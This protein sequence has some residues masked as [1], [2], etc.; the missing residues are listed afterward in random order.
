MKTEFARRCYK[1]LEHAIERQH[2]FF[3]VS[4]DF[5][6]DLFLLL[7]LQEQY[8]WHRK[9]F[10]RNLSLLH[11]NEE[12]KY[13]E[14]MFCFEFVRFIL[15]QMRYIWKI[16][17]LIISNFDLYGQLHQEN[18]KMSTSKTIAENHKQNE[19]QQHLVVKITIISAFLSKN[20]RIKEKMW[21]ITLLEL[22]ALL[23]LS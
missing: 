5:L 19:N 4:M 8:F 10:L 11:P 16:V 21:F 17:L 1:H 3:H 20:Q 9:N 18:V 13:D 23:G 14:A 7:R 2:N 22:W 12:T 6:H 15:K